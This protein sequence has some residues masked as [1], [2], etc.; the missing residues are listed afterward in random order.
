M[1]AGQ[2]FNGVQGLQL[3]PAVTSGRKALR[4]PGDCSLPECVPSS[5]NSPEVLSIAIMDLL[6]AYYPRS[7]PSVDSRYPELDNIPR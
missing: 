5:I 1:P 2:G 3:L 4:L 7:V 6:D